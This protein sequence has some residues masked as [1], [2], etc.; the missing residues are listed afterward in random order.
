MGS[1]AL[2]MMF[3][4]MAFFYLMIG[5]GFYKHVIEEAPMS[6]KLQKML[7]WPVSLG[8]IISKAEEDIKQFYSYGVQ[9]KTIENIL[10]VLQHRD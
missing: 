8:Y 10:S 3:I 2:L 4:F 5:L 9:L 6:Y 7:F 1:I